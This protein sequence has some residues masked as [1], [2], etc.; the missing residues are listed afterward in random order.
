VNAFRYSDGSLVTLSPLDSVAY[1]VNEGG[2]VVGYTGAPFQ[3]AFRWT[4]SNGNGVVD[5]GEFKDLGT[6]LGGAWS[7]AYAINNLGDVVG[8]AKHSSGARRGFL[9]TDKGGMQDVGTL[10]GTN[11]LANAIDNLGRVV[12]WAQTPGGVWHAFLRTTGPLFLPVNHDLNDLLPAGSGWALI[13]AF[14]IND[15][16][17]IVGYGINPSGQERGFLMTPLIHLTA[18][19]FEPSTVVGGNPALLRA[20]LDAPAPAGGVIVT[21]SGGPGSLVIPAGAT[22]ATVSVA[23]APVA[24]QM[25][26][27]VRGALGA[28]WASAG[29][30]IRPIG[31]GSLTIKPNQVPGGSVTTGT[32]TLER[33]AAPG[34]ISVSLT[35]ANPAIAS[36]PTKITIPAGSSTGTFSITTTCVTVNTKVSIQAQANGI[37]K[38]AV[39][40]VERSTFCP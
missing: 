12:G 27:L 39:L 26:W 13:D 14:D 37:S 31:V 1:A 30:K 35:S 3:R 29:L 20:T 36:V 28:E 11:S 22:S 40:G 19:A 4:D 2:Q 5:P 25:L 18:L 34:N 9:W 23:T 10:G 32:V 6:L 16:G 33:P 17:Q 8:E 7:I 21:L 38:I 15:Q 24:S